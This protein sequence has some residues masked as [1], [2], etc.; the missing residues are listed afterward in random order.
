MES[1]CLKCKKYTKDIN[2]KVSSTINGKLIILS[3]CTICDTKKINL[4]KNKK[5]KEY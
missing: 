3:K 4:L 2:P 1:Y 5:Q